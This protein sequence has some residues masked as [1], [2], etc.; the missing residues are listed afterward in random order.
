L[1]G[2]AGAS[3]DARARRGGSDRRSAA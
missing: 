3:H 2:M 1:G